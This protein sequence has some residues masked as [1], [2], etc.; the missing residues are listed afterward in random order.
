LEKGDADEAI[1]HFQKAIQVDP[2]NA[3][4]ENNLG[5][6]FLQKGN[7][8]EAFAHFEQALRIIPDQP[9]IQNNLAWIYATSQESSLRNGAKAVELARQ[10][11]T[12]SGGENPTVL[13][14][15]AAAYAEA[16][17]FAEAKAT[18]QRAL[19]LAETQSNSTLAG[20]LQ[21]EL[22]LYQAGKPLP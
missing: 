10:A 22:K 1:I 6:A 11:N 12:L 5:N 15:L 4:A 20:Q 7:T 16:G 17:R 8:G 21:S 14:T 9:A 13:R 2:R 19:T 3:K 18:V